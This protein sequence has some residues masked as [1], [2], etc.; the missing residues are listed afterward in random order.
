MIVVVG[1]HCCLPRS[2]PRQDRRLTCRPPAHP[3]RQRHR[4]GGAVPAQQPH[5]RRRRRTP[6]R[7]SPGVR[8]ADASLALGGACDRHAPGTSPRR[9]ARAR[10]TSAGGPLGSPTPDA[11]E[12]GVP[13]GAPLVG[14]PRGQQVRRW[15]ELSQCHDLP[16]R[17]RTPAGVETAGTHRTRGGCRAPRTRQTGPAPSSS[18]PSTPPTG[19][20]SR[21]R[22]TRRTP[23]NASRGR[24]DVRGAPA[25]RHGPASPPSPSSTAPCAPRRG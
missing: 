2:R 19:P 3:G 16:P 5:R 23:S 4:I 9:L 15:L 25:D 12:T 10:P 21:H 1:S 14:E 7:G 8:C 18:R 13:G 20:A 22:T 17:R 24:R 6:P 11:A